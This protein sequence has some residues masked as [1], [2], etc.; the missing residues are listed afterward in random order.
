MSNGPIEDANDEMG[1]LPDLDRGALVA[2]DLAC[3]ETSGSQA[4]R[5]EAAIRAYL[6]AAQNPRWSLADWRT[7][8][9]THRDEV[10]RP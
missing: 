9:I 10:P 5:T 4:A 7:L 1:R 2:A 8:A 3:L 6:W